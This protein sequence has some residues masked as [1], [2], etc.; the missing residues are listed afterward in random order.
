MVPKGQSCGPRCFDQAILQ[1]SLALIEIYL[2]CSS[3]ALAHLAL[4]TWLSCC[5]AVVLS[6]W[7]LVLPLASRW[8]QASNIPVELCLTSK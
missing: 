4:M 1:L 5:R 8:C 6:C 2:F 7:L 3:G